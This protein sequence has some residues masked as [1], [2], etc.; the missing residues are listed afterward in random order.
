[1]LKSPVL[2]SARLL[3]AAVICYFAAAAAAAGQEPP[4]AGSEKKPADE[5][6]ADAKV[7]ANKAATA[8]S[9]VE[10][11]ILI[12]GGLGGRDRLNQIRKTSFERGRLSIANETGQMEQATYQVWTIR[13]ENFEKEKIRFDQ[14][15]PTVRYSLVHTGDKTFGIYNNS[16]FNPRADAART[17]ENR[18]YHGLE[19]LLRYKENGSTISLAGREKILGVDFY[20]IDLTDKQGRKT[21]YYISAKTYRVM[22]ID[23]EDNGVKY[24]RKFYD[25]N[26]AQG[27]LV[28]Y[29]ST[30]SAG[31]KIVEETQVLTV[32][33]GQKVDDGLFAE[34]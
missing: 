21:R 5:K 23:Y 28:P 17:F 1:M 12:Y 24:R 33:F 4:K 7:D 31:D 25:Y 2:L 26:Y 30:L 14:E 18:I 32:T 20:L 10:S 6:K 15:Y 13:G 3:F 9:V 16:V 11:T 8:E 22:M 19:A 27:T 34:G 29:R